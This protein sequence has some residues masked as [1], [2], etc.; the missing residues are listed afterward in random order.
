MTA[1]ELKT[2]IDAYGGVD[3]LLGF[4]FDNSAGVTFTPGQFS[5]SSNLDETN[6][7]LKFTQYD[8]NGL[9]YMT[10]KPT[11]TIQAIMI[12]DSRIQSVDMYDSVSIRG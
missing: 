6:N 3:F 4:G 2:L 1:S 5:Y 9:P 12:K 7:V 10:L 11:D 8:R